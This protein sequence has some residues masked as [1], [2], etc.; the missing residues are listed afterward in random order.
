[1]KKEYLIIPIVILALLAAFSA[2]ASADESCW[3]DTFSDETGI[4]VKHNVTVADGNVTL[5]G[6]TGTDHNGA[7]WTP[8]NGAEISGVHYNIGTFT[9]AAGTT[10]YV[11]P[12]ATETGLDGSLEIHAGTI[13]ILGE[14]NGTGKGYPGGAGAGHYYYSNY[15]CWYPGRGTGDGGTHNE[16]DGAGQYPPTG[17]DYKLSSG[18]GGGYGGEGGL[19]C[20]YWTGYTGVGDAPGGDAYGTSNTYLLKIG[21]SGAGGGGGCPEPGCDNPPCCLWGG[22]GGAGGAGILLDA[23]TVT[24]D[25][26][27]N[28]NAD[29]G[30]DGETGYKGCGGGGGGAGGSIEINAGTLSGSG[31]LYAEGGDGGDAGDGLE[32]GGHAAGGAGGGGGGRIKVW[33]ASSTFSGSH[34]VMYGSGGAH[35]MGYYGNGIDG[36]PGEEGT[37]Y[38]TSQ[39][40]SPCTPGGSNYKPSGYLKSIA[41]TPASMESWGMF[42]ANHTEN[43]ETN[44]SYQIQN[45]TDDSTL[46]T[47]TASQAATGY[48][49]SSCADATDSIRLYADLNTMD[50]SNTPVLHDWTVCW[51]VGLPT[52]PTSFFISGWVNNSA[53]DPVNNPVVNI[54]NTNTPEVFT[55]ETIA[56]SNYYQV[57][58]SSENVSAGDVLHFYARDNGNEEEFDHTVTEAEMN[59]GGF[60]QNITVLFPYKDLIVTRIDAYH[61]ETFYPDERYPPYFNLSNEIDVTVENAGTEVANPSHV[62]LYID[63][64]LYGKRSVPALDAGS[65]ATVQFKWTPTGYDCEDDGSNATYTLK[66]IADC[67]SEIEELYEGNNESTVQEAAY[68]AGWSAEEVLLQVFNGTIKGG[69]NFTTGDGVYTGLYSP[70]ASTDIHYDITLPGGASVEL[71]RLNVYY[72]WSYTDSATGKTGVYA[73]MGVSIT[74]TTSGETHTLSTDKKYNDRPCDS[75]AI[76][77]DYPYGNYVYD[78]TP[79]I[80]GSG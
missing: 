63:G 41:I 58:T 6:G 17:E 48:D 10:V 7:S 29:D 26:A 72:T 20:S 3:D 5:A 46:C 11:A 78:L 28:V 34:S 14:L 33:Y 12:Y 49:I 47:I 75:P 8:A 54:T 80:N 18:G 27:I 66:A 79:Y 60:E 73:S 25:G 61:N 4:A 19:G 32:A 51:I 69:L 65:N 13:N 23:A 76:N 42:S 64:E 1:M 2:P 67:D 24:I 59:A 57:L 62:S 35:G 50:P 68:W 56:T 77:F 9:V 15:S 36:F 21:A 71:A 38:S 52:P 55:A 37:Y 70:G 16:V 74:N 43:A 30:G 45:A 22:N 44:I 40:Y 39:T 31:S 53:G